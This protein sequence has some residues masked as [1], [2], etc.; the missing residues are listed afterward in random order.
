MG[1]IKKMFSPK[2]PGALKPKEPEVQR[3]PDMNDPAI[4]EARRRRMKMESMSRGR[5]STRLSDSRGSAGAK[6]AYTG[7]VLGS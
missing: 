1:G 5:E 4:E 7:G 3:I 2:I 6:P